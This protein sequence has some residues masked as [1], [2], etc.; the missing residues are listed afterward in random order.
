MANLEKLQ[1]ELQSLGVP[2]YISPDE[3]K[4]KR[5]DVLF[6]KADQIF[7]EAKTLPRDMFEPKEINFSLDLSQR[8]LEAYD[9]YH[10]MRNDVESICS[11]EKDMARDIAEMVLASAKQKCLTLCQ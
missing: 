10:L 4:D 11:F 7:E 5:L 3:R 2:C 6:I 9:I 1:E 8:F